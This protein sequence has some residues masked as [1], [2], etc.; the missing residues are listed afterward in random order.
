MVDR[1]KPPILSRKA[2]HEPS[3][4]DPENLPREARRQRSIAKVAPVLDIRRNANGG[5]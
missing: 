1:E 4:F 2:D 3:V 5:R